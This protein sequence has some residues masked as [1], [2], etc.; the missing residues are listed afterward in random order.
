[1]TSVSP[2]SYS[3][4]DTPVG[5]TPPWN[6]EAEQAVVGA[7]MLDQD[8]ALRAV[9]LLDPAMFYRE[10]HRRLFRAMAALTE[11]RIVIDHIT[12]RDELQRRGELDEA[13]GVEYL[14]EL[15][16]SV[17]TAANLEYHA[18]IV[19]EKAILRHLIETATS[20]IGEAY[21]GRSS[22]NELLDSAES[23][24]FH[25][26]QQRREA[27]FTRIKEMLWPTME[28][29]EMLHRS[30]KTITGVPSG[31]VDLDEMTSGF[32]KSELIIVAARPSMGKTSFCL[33]IATHAALVHPPVG[34][35]VFSLEMSKNSLVQRMLCAE[36]R[37]DS[38][39]VRRG[40]L[41]DH[42]FTKLARAAGIL[43]G[44]PIWI[45]DTPAM[46][47]LEMRSKARRLKAEY[48]LGL[49]VVDYLQ[50]MRS[51][52]YSENRVQEISDISRSLKALAR[53]LEIPVMALS[54]LSRASEQRGGDRKPILSD[55]RD[56]GAIEQDA[57]VVLFIH[58]PEMYN[59]E[60]SEG[61]SLEGAAEI[62]VAKHRNG[63]TGTL[64]LH[65]EKSITR[66]D[67]LSE[68]E[69]PA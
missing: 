4:L 44:A 13:G 68:R 19:R 14:A 18:N 38:Q 58:R 36:A 9:E 37:V 27:G 6:A 24:V 26:S 56:S 2:D 39:L 69:A 49:I 55:L 21:A 59:R 66:F 45:D 15:V 30:G 20:I 41:R 61:R 54:Q 47:L 29:I 53:E 17:P 40:M 5:R 3:T 52:E 42:D 28:R 57:D 10:A 43:Q 46:T 63:P 25:I 12:L 23:R 62:I 16:D 34:V 50:L 65:F 67:N 7:M 11:Q 48:D 1:M 51:P 35:A 32:Q 64:D 22:A 8:A 31:F 60:D 33:N